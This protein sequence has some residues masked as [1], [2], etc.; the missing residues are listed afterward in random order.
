MTLEELK[1]EAK[2]H[3]YHLIKDREKV[4]LLDCTCGCKR[5]F[6][7]STIKDWQSYEGLECAKCGKRVWGKTELDARKEWNKLIEEEL[8]ANK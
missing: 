1:A 7:L 8:S 5:R 2:K 6:H 4:N 3:G